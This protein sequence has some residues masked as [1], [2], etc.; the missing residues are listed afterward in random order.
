MITNI[1]P[2][3]RSRVLIENVIVAEPIKK[4][5]FGTRCVIIIFIGLHYSQKITIHAFV[6]FNFRI[7][8]D[9]ILSDTSLFFEWYLPFR[10]YGYNCICISNIFHACCMSRPCLQPDSVT[11]AI[12]SEECQLGKFSLYNCL[13]PPV[14]LSFSGSNI[15]FSKL[16]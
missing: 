4:F 3:S 11:S 12:F 8:F 9:T 6:S 2:T 13:R 14:D 15:V 1:S 5:L 7:Q 16:L 10:M